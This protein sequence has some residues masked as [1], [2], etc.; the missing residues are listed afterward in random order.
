MNF[1]LET[2]KSDFL[3]TLVRLG[4]DAKKA[5]DWL[6]NVFAVFDK[7]RSTSR[8]RH[9]DQS[10][11]NHLVRLICDPSLSDSTGLQHVPYTGTMGSVLSGINRFLGSMTI[12]PSQYKHILI[13]MVGGITVNEIKGLQRG[14]KTNESEIII[15]STQ[16][17]TPARL[18]QQLFFNQKVFE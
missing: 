11:C 1:N 5:E 14:F 3:E 16:I 8:G 9:T 10:L 4:W 6:F 7:I 17:I 12:H 15:G 13:F 18:C 2:M